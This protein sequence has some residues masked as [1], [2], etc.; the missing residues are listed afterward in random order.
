MPG[1]PELV[2]ASADEEDRPVFVPG[3]FWWKV[4]GGR[5]HHRVRDG[6]EFQM[7][8]IYRKK[9]KTRDVSGVS[10]LVGR[11]EQPPYEEKVIQMMWDVEVW[12]EEAAFKWWHDNKHRY[13][14][15]D[16][17]TGRL[18]VGATKRTSLSE[19]TNK[20]PARG[21]GGGSEA[22]TQFGQCQ[23]PRELVQARGTDGP[24]VPSSE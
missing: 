6:G 13:V 5:G 2:Q 15:A 21:M 18:V 22:G 12:T 20:H 11:T 10:M 23:D 19:I 4:E 3:E 7:W 1:A 16:K 17:G 9:D 24:A 8:S 14:T